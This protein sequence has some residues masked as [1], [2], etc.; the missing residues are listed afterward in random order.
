MGAAG[1]IGPSSQHVRRSSSCRRSQSLSGWFYVRKKKTCFKRFSRSQRR[2]CPVSRMFFS[3][4]LSRHFRPPLSLFL[5][6][7][8]P[9]SVS[10][11]TQFGHVTHTT[12]AMLKESYLDALER[13]SLLAQLIRKIIQGVSCWRRSRRLTSRRYKVHIRRKTMI[14]VLPC[15][16]V[17]CSLS[18]VTFKMLLS[19]KGNSST[20]STGWR[21]MF[22][23]I[24]GFGSPEVW[25][26]RI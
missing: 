15:L 7:S 8:F 22:M 2:C 17:S 3:W 13:T 11:G 26:M 9:K 19:R 4:Y 24:S 5:L 25:W 21:S 16:L 20:T 23:L 12:D 10:R 1:L 14:L 6:A 18:Q